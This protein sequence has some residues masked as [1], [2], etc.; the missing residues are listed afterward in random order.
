MTKIYFIINPISGKGKHE[1]SQAY[2]DTFF[3]S[4]KYQVF[5]KYSTYKKHAIV[6]TQEA[7]TQGADVIVACGGDGTIHEVATELVGKEVRFGIV[8]VGSGN[9]LASNLSIPKDIEQAIKRVRDGKSMRMDVGSVNGEYFFSNMGFGIDATIIDN[10]EKSGKR[11]LSAYIKASLNSAQ[12]YKAKR[13]R[14][15]YQGQVKEVN[16]LLLFISNS[17]EMGYNMTLTPKASLTDGQLDYLMVP[18]INIFKQLT[19]GLY[20]LLKKTDR[21]RKT[22]YVQTDYIK[23]EIIDQSRNG[24]QMDGEYYQYDTNHFEIKVLKGALHVIY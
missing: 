17:N 23:V 6:L 20:V 5:A 18:K 13:M 9:G 21:F 24:L 7:I 1:I 22:D 14:V 19:F 3:D 11:K 2:L 8:P 4:D 15:S 12:N 10:Y 16:P